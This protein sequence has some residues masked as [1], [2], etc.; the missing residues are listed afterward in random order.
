MK[1]TTVTIREINSE[2]FNEFKAYAIRNKIN[3][4]G[5]MNMAMIKLMAEGKN[6]RKFS[7]FKP[8]DWGKG[9]ERVSEQV[10]EILYGE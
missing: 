4:G 8:V 3:L 10:D 5:A 2:T 6:R 7:D 9:N 1:K